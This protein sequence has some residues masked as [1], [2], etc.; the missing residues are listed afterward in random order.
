MLKRNPG[1]SSFS[2]VCQVLN[3]DPSEDIAPEKIPLLRYAPG[4]SSVAERSFSAYK[5]T[6]SD[7][8][9]SMALEDKEK[10]YNSV[11]CIKESMIE[12][13]DFK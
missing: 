5:H 2:S 9:L 10:D 6:L 13:K 12:P 3:V 4:I 1:F 8:I 11:L 7:N